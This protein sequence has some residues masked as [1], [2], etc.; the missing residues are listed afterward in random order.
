MTSGLHSS[1]MIGDE[2][3][4]GAAPILKGRGRLRAP[5]TGNRIQSTNLGKFESPH[6]PWHTVDATSLDPSGENDGI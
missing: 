3:N 5:G 1:A 4:F 6:Q 2:V